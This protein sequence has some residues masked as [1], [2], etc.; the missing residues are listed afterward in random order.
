MAATAAGP[1][2]AG[3]S[4]AGSALA[5]GTS[6]VSDLVKVTYRVKRGDTLVSIARLFQTSVVSLQ[7]WNGIVGTK[8]LLNQPLTV[9]APVGTN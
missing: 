8:I 7:L 2:L 4:A 5:L 9:Y 1:S 3:A 6:L